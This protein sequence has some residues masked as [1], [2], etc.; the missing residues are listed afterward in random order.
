MQGFAAL[1]V[2]SGSFVVLGWSFATQP[3]PPDNHQ[4]YASCVKVYPRRHCALQYMPST[5]E[6]MERR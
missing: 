4:A 2:L 6:A 3:L 1:V 5:V